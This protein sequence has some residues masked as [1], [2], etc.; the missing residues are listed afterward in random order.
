MPFKFV[1]N[2]LF[3]I[4]CEAVG[5]FLEGAVDGAFEDV[6]I[7][8]LAGGAAGVVVEIHV[9]CGDREGRGSGFFVEGF[10]V[11]ISEVEERV[12]WGEEGVVLWPGFGWRSGA[13]ARRAV[14]GKD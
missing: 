13:V 4:L 9:H 7:F 14:Q 6:F 10:V 2:H 8:F 5:E 11:G 3:W 12:G 1:P